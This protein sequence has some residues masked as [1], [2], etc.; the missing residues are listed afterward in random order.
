MR[1]KVLCTIYVSLIH[2]EGLLQ[3]MKILRMMYGILLELQWQIFQTHLY[4]GILVRCFWYARECS[5]WTFSLITA[6][7]VCLAGIFGGIA[8]DLDHDHGR[9]IRIMFTISAV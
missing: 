6:P 8:P 4:G 3:L 1:I 2:V 5:S 9:P 7:I